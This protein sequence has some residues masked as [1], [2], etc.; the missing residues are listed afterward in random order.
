MI[1]STSATDTCFFPICV[2]HDMQII[3]RHRMPM[4]T[5]LDR[6]T[7]RGSQRFHLGR[8][9]FETHTN[10]FVVQTRNEGPFSQT[11][12]DTMECQETIIP[13]I[14]RLFESRCPVTVFRSIWTIVITAFNGV[15]WSWPSPHIGIEARKIMPS[16]A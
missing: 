3:A 12:G 13:F 1:I 2:S 6:L 14:S 7:Q 5:S 16:L 4:L 9:T 11:F 10:G 15:L 8:S